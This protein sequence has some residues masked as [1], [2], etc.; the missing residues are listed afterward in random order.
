MKT[1]K[2]LPFL[3]LIVTHCMLCLAVNRKHP[4]GET[5]D[6]SVTD[7]DRQKR[8]FIDSD[9]SIGGGRF[10]KRDGFRK[11]GKA[12]GILRFLPIFD[13]FMEPDSANYF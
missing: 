11:P 5:N 10:G 9:Y 1:K 12:I 3:F 8:I 6:K 7:W 4:I 13:D 2:I